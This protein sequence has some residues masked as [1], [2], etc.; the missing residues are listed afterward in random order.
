ME[1]ILTDDQVAGKGYLAHPVAFAFV[2]LEG[3]VD[4]VFP[5][6][7]FGLAHFGI[8][9]P[10]IAVIGLD[11]CSIPIQKFFLEH[12]GSGQPGKHAPGGQGQFVLDIIGIELFGPFDGDAFDVELLAF[13]DG[14]IQPGPAGF[15]RFQVIADLGV[16]IP[17]FAV[18][19]PD[20][21]HVFHKDLGVEY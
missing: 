8:H 13:L 4:A 17:L 7:D 6:I 5:V 14:D 21:V 3:D 15:G 2:D 10:P 9:E 18:E 1:G 12:A 20:L 19:V 16:V 11:G